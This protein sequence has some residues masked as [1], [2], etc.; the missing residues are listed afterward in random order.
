MITYNDLEDRGGTIFNKRT[1][2]PYSRPEDLARDLGVAPHQIQWENIPKSNMGYG[3]KTTPTPVVTP[4]PKITP[5]P[6]NFQTTSSKNAA[7][8]IIN[9]TPQ[10]VQNFNNQFTTYT[11]NQ[12]PVSGDKYDPYSVLSNDGGTIEGLDGRRFQTPEELAKFLGIRPDQIE[13]NKIKPTVILSP[14]NTSTGTSSPVPT[15]QPT[16]NPIVDNA[17]KRLTDMGDEQ[18]ASF[19]ALLA[20]NK[21]YL[22]ELQKRGQMLNPNVE[23]TPEKT[24]EFLTQAQGEISPYYN[25]Q[26]KMARETL[27]RSAGYT[28]DEILRNEAEIEKKYGQGVRQIGETMAESG[29]ALSGRRIEGEQNLAE[30]TQAT[31]DAN[32]R[33]A[34]FEAGNQARQFASEWG[35]T[36][37]PSV[38]YQ[39]APR[40]LAGVGSFAKMGDTKPFYNISDSVYQGLKGSRQYEQDV[41]QRQRSSELEGLY[42]TTEEN[43]LRKL[44]I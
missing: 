5:T 15:Q 4:T 21:K 13:W 28:T 12:P 24:A 6:D 39:N 27:L 44:S 26:M 10:D 14:Q 34:E 31:I 36:E 2:T 29:F 11:P 23:I 41:A 9:P 35:G 40:V 7:G 37:M 16:G 19:A 38:S 30:E 22:D 1:M 43:R 32:R 42:R 17:I 20:E 3:A 25:T 18:S 8:E 33:R